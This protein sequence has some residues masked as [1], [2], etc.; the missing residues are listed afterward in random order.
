L[1]QVKKSHLDESYIVFNPQNFKQHTH[2]Q[3]RGVAFAVKRNV[4]KKLLPKTNNIWLLVSH[5]RVSSDRNYI[6]AVQAKI[7]SL[8]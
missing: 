8:N 2:I 1:L 3:N 5:I 6:A 4:E 7:D